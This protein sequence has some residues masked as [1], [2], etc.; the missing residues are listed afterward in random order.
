MSAVA[1]YRNRSY[2][3][4]LLPTISL[5]LGA[6]F[7]ATALAQ[8]APPSTSAPAFKGVIDLDV[9]KSTPDWGPYTAKKAP[10]G[11]PNVLFVLYDDTGLAAWSPYG[12]R[13]N[14]PTLDKLAADGL[15]Y[16]QFHTA[17]LC[18]PTRSILQTGRNHHVNGMASITE[19]ANGYPE[20][21]RA[22]AMDHAAHLAAVAALQAMWPEITQ[23]QASAEAVNAVA[24]ASSH[25]W[26]WLWRGVG[27]R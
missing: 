17:A 4:A 23:K 16:T 6:M 21:R 1:T 9:R 5:A 3:S 26:K 14:M 13:I 8:Q 2:M 27:S 19:G 12:G 10:E 11:A 7:S 24:Y 25:H 20:K 15:T 22:G 18:S